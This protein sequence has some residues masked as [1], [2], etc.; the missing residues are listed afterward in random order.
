MHHRSAAFPKAIWATYFEPN[1]VVSLQ[2][3]FLPLT[4]FVPRSF[5]TGDTGKPASEGTLLW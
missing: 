5:S 1:L 4:P 2:A 3:P